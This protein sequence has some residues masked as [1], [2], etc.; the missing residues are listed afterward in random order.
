M[1]VF[2]YGDSSAVNELSS[3]TKGRGFEVVEVACNLQDIQATLKENLVDVV[4]LDLDTPDGR[5]VL[6]WVHDNYPA[7]GVVVLVKESTEEKAVFCVGKARGYLRY[8]IDKARLASIVNQL[9]NVLGAGRIS[10]DLRRRQAY[11]GKTPIKLTTVRFKILAELVKNAGQT[12]SYSD[13][14]QAVYG[15]NMDNEQA[16]NKLKTHVQY[17][18]EDLE[19]ATGQQII[20]RRAGEVFWVNK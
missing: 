5:P 20:S 4:V 19:K 18:H 12:L 15:E 9:V 3:V 7:V 10:I 17:L 16:T 2:A 11:W 14:A 1:V 8:P 13:L 6:D